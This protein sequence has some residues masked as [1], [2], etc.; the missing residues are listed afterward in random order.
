M[1]AGTF[2][3]YPSHSADPY[4]IRKPKKA[5]PEPVFR[6]SPGP[7]STPVKS[8]IT[9][10]VNRFIPLSWILFFL[11]SSLGNFKSLHIII[12]S[13]DWESLWC[14]LKIMVVSNTRMTD[15]SAINWIFDQHGARDKFTI[16]R[17]FCVCCLCLLVSGVCTLQATLRL[18]QL[19]WHSDNKCSTAL[20]PPS[21]LPSTANDFTASIGWSAMMNYIILHS[22][23]QRWDV[24]VSHILSDIVNI[25]FSCFYLLR[26]FL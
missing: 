3:A 17:M 9:V 6:P 19:W 11:Y 15:T 16:T 22:V 14:R 5:H 23:L 24:A 2:G 26:A 12:K 8:I 10:N 20:H 13:R 18:F 25:H 7:K 21:Y 1:K 4:V